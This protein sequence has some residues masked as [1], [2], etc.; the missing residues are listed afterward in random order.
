MEA[1]SPD[2]LESAIKWRGWSKSSVQKTSNKQRTTSKGKDV[3]M[4]VGMQMASHWA[5]QFGVP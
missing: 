2:L 3:E 4:L 1:W 5:I